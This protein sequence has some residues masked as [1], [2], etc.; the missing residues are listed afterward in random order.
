MPRQLALPPNLLPRIITREAAAAFVCVSPNTFDEMVN[1]GVM[2]KAKQLSPKRHGWDVR[3]L[4]AAVDA[5][6][7]D[8][9]KIEIGS[10]E[11]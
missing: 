4:D 5:L 3:D 9:E 7:H 8:G 11:G 6:P 2:P 1:S 10:D